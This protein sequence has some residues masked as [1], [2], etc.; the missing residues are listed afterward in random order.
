VANIRRA[1]AAQGGSTITQQ[2]ARQSFLTTDKTL[3]RKLQEV[4]L[5]AEIERAF[6]KEEILE[7]YLNKVYFGDGFYGVEAASLGF[8][9]KHAAEVDVAEAALL[10]GLIRSPS[11]YAPT[12][13]LQRAT[14]RRGV[15][16]QAMLQAEAI[17]RSTFERARTAKVVLQN[18]L[19]RD[20]G[21]GLHFKEHVRRAL[22]E[23]FGWERVYQGGLKVYTTLDPATQKAAEVHVER[24]LAEIE[25]RPAF[26]RTR[27]RRA[28]SLGLPEG[29]VP[30][31]E[32]LQAALMAIDPLTGHVR[33]MIG[34]RSFE[35]SSF[36]RAV[37][38]RRQPGSAFKPFVYAVA[39]ET[40]FTPASVLA[41]LDDPIATDQGDYM[42][43]DDHSEASS[44]TLR[45]ALRTSSNRAAVHLL[46]E[47]GIKRTVDY[48]TK[49]SVGTV[50]SVPSLALGAGEVTVES[51][52]TAYAAFASGG[53][54]R[55]AVFIRRVEDE[56]G[57]ILFQ[58]EERA[59]RALSATTAFLMANMLAD[60]INSGTAYRARREGF[61]LPAAG[62]TGTTNDYNDAWFVGFTPTLVAGVWVG[63]DQPQTIMGNGYA[64]DLAVPIWA[65]FMK[66]ATAGDKP[67]WFARPDGVVGVDV[68]RLSGKRPA[69]GC[70]DVH[71]VS[72]TG[73]TRSRSMV[74]TEYFAGGTQ[75]ME[76]CPLHQRSVFDRVAGI[77]GTSPE[78]PPVI[79]EAA[80][81][82]PVVSPTTPEPSVT[83]APPATAQ[84][85]EEPK[86]KRGFWSRIFGRR[87][88]DKGERDQGQDR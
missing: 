8:F 48:A 19:G 3:R 84:K 81:P 16:L 22:V 39:L 4:V 78:P 75:P 56:A 29:Q 60:V 82:P 83:A 86:K 44:M 18:A 5:A 31:N 58:A 73:E 30:P 14:A 71:V 47:V 1:R 37:Q 10:A 57:T 54:V 85:V 49:L 74:Y 6:T 87:D 38:A 32:R 52:T 11:T 13:N 77:F 40:G 63:F 25:A 64:A 20:E 70:Y 67:V 53:V 26:L 27:A 68:C 12:V 23:Q 51:M 76:E 15:V 46:Q 65:N 34:G 59:T 24:G 2:L 45:T 17:D 66:E 9:G 79:P 88:R 28:V 69:G 36:N 61:T 62:K 43:E 80:A 42:P 72:N 50:P 55:P 7:L 21:F 41:N 33:A 35:E